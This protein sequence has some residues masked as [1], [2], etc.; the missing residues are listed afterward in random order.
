MPGTLSY[1]RNG[2]GV[3][4]KFDPYR[5][6]QSGKMIPL[7]AH[8]G[9]PHQCPKSQYNQQKQQQQQQTTNFGNAYSGNQ[10][11]KETKAI[12]YRDVH[13]NN[14]STSSSDN[15]VVMELVQSQTVSLQHIEQLLEHQIT[16]IQDIK[17][18]LLA[19]LHPNPTLGTAKQI[20]DDNMGMSNNYE[21]AMVEKPLD[22]IGED[23]TANE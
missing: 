17:D 20:Y 8:S 7:E 14:T 12:D 4:I 15:L 11:A 1:C 6:S 22:R 23:K 10:L 16:L 13:D 21:S 3:Q 5:K 19:S 18:A 9:E 2:C